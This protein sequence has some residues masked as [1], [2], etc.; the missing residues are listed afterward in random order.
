MTDAA[1]AM[2]VDTFVPRLRS[3]SQ[4]LD[5]GAEH[6]RAATGDPD[7]FVEA[8]LAP[9]MFTLA[10]QIK[11]ACDFALKAADQLIGTETPTADEADST[12][13]RMRA[14]IAATCARLEALPKAA[15]DGAGERE[16]V[17][18]LAGGMTL[19]LTGLQM[20]KDW[21]L[22]NF[23]FHV[24]TAYDILRH[25]GVQIGK[26]DY[27]SDIGPMIRQRSAAS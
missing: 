21:T 24:I 25:N 5:K 9:D 23:Y 11:L 17:I 7:A 15:F 4:I 14:R 12:M 27:M 2:S 3:L 8:R 13:E 19:E 16:L 6:A 20:L 10:A 18:P 22:P 26:Q 1:Y